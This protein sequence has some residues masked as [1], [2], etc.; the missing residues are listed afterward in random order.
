MFSTQTLRQQ[1][2]P[3]IIYSWPLTY[4]LYN[5]CY[6]KPFTMQIVA[7]SVAMAKAPLCVAQKAK[8]SPMPAQKAFKAASFTAKPLKSTRKMSARAMSGKLW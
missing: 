2:G 1:Q 4:H 5:F 6:L 7:S 3:S 8:N